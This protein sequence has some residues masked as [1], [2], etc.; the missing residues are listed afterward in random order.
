MGSDRPSPRLSA[1]AFN[2]WFYGLAAV[3]AVVVLLAV[4]VWKVTAAREAA[5]KSNCRGHLK[6]LALALHNYADTYGTFPPVYTVDDSGRPLHSWRTLLLPFVDQLALYKRLDLSKPWNDP[7]NQ[8]AH[9]IGIEAYACPSGDPSRTTYHA[10]ATADSVLRVERSLA[11]GEIRDKPGDTLMVI[12]VNPEQAV[13]WMAPEDSGAEFLRV[14]DRNTRGTHGQGFGLFHAILADGSIVT[15]D[16]HLTAA[17]RAGLAT[18]AAG[19]PVT[20]HPPK[21]P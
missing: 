6:Y 14:F 20:P 1:A 12:E 19:D 5:R 4:G 3:L 13:H 17:D 9:H 18:A 11:P 10:V 2:R 15:F 8:F 21:Y 7:V 16:F